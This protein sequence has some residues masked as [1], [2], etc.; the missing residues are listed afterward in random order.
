MLKISTSKFNDQRK[1]I[2]F[3]TINV[4]NKGR[5]GTEALA[6]RAAVGTVG[7]AGTDAADSTR[8]ATD[9]PTYQHSTHS[10]RRSPPANLELYAFIT[11]HSD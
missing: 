10:A 3:Y 8:A 11:S 2:N 9:N 6:A 7:T 5:V 1:I 4:H